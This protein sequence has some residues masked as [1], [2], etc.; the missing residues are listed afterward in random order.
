MLISVHK[1]WNPC[2]SICVQMIFV[3]SMFTTIQYFYFSINNIKSK[4][5]FFENK[6]NFLLGF[7]KTQKSLTLSCKYDFILTHS[8]VL[9]K[10]CSSNCPLQLQTI[11]HEWPFTILIFWKD[12][13]LIAFRMHLLGTFSPPFQFQTSTRHFRFSFFRSYNNTHDFIFSIDDRYNKTNR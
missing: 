12:C 8:F 5:N 1:F 9:T 7:W 13:H 10:N 4:M 6:P 11:C 2:R 3:H